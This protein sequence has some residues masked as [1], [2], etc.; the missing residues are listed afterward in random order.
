MTHPVYMKPFAKRDADCKYTILAEFAFEVFRTLARETAAMFCP[1]TVGAVARDACSMVLARIVSARVCCCRLN[2]GTVGCCTHKRDSS[3]REQTLARK[4]KSVFSLLHRLL[5]WRYPCLLLSDG[6]SCT[7]PA[8][9]EVQ[10]VRRTIAWC[11]WE[12]K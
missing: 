12:G 1:G 9:I 7:A 11:C 5:T 3:W 8:V 4:N 10:N 2:T 6:A